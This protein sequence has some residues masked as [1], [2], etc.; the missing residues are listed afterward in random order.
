MRKFIVLISI[1]FTLLLLVMA[2]AFWLKPTGQVGGYYERFASPK[3]YSLILGSS[4]A[5]QDI[6]PMVIDSVFNNVYKLPIYNYSFAIHSSPYGAVYTKSILRKLAHNGQRHSLFILAVDPF[7]IGNSLTDVEGGKRREEG[8]YLDNMWC[9]HHSPNVEYLVRYV[10]LDK[11]FYKKTTSKGFINE[12][13]RYVSGFQMNEDSSE[14][15]ERIHEVILP[16]YYD[17]ILPHYSPSNERIESL[18]Q[19]VR[20]LREQGDVFLVRLP[21]GP[22][23][24]MIMD[25][26]YPNFDQQMKKWTVEEGVS[27]INFKSDSLRYRT[28][29]GVHLYSLE[30]SRLTQALCDSIKALKQHE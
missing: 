17:N 16:D 25:S 15:F 9:V 21:V 22:E 13:G 29:D 23:I 8:G 28:T 11:Q 2:G 12:S 6:D 7:S 27:Y 14:V 20:Q 19:L 26:I 18:M 5:A 1:F 3:A 24:S 4:M 30:G 10:V